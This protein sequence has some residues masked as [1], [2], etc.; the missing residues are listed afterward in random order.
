M[1]P[2]GGLL[3]SWLHPA[4]L[5]ASVFVGWW[6]IWFTLGR[7]FR[8]TLSML[9][10]A[11]AV[12]TLGAFGLLTSGALGVEDP[13]S[14]P[15]LIAWIAAAAVLW[16]L[17]WGVETIVLGIMMRHRH[18]ASWTWNGYDLVVLGVAHAAHVSGALLILG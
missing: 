10:A 15:G 6:A 18:S 12:S 7:A 4:L 16:L 9:G 3:A 8:E 14:E 5:A 17:A 2:L 13:S 1:S 11:R